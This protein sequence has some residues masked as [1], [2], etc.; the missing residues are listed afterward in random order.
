VIEEIRRSDDSPD[1]LLSRVLFE[2]AYQ[3]HPYRKEVIGTQASVRS[4]TREGLIEFYRSWYVPNNMTFIAVGDFDPAVALEQIKKSFANAKPRAD[5]AHPRAPEPEQTAARAAVVPSQFE[6]SL[7][8]VG[9]KITEFQ[10]PDTPYLDL[11]GMVLGSGDSSRLS[12]EV[13]DRAQLV[14]GIHASSYTPLDPGLFVVDAELDA[15]KIDVTVTAIAEQVRR[16]RDLGP[17]ETE[18]ERA[19]T[20]LLASQVHERETMRGQAQKLG[21]FALLAGG[22][23]AE[24]QYPRRVRRAT[25]R[26]AARREQYL[27]ARARDRGRADREGGERLGDQAQLLGALGAAGS[28]ASLPYNELRDGIRQYTLHNGLRVVV[29]RNA[30]VPLVSLR[31]SFLGGLL[32]ETESTQGITSFV[33]EM[34]SRG[35]MSR[36]SAQLAA[37][38][39]D[40][41]GELSGFSG[42]NSSAYKRSSDESLDTGW[43]SSP[44]CCCAR[45][46]IL[47][48]SKLKIE[49]RAALRCREDSLST[50][51]FELF[52]Q[53]IYPTTRTAS[54]RSAPRSRSRSSIARSQYFTLRAAREQGARV[55]ATSGPHR[56]RD[57]VAPVGLAGHG[58]VAL[59]REPPVARRRRVCSRRRRRRRTVRVLALHLGPRPA[60]A[61]R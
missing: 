36:S 16:I 32:A 61:R 29:K 27:I 12:R 30:N 43:I 1:N 46:S 2:T 11:L 24:A 31:L 22:I 28:A 23:D 6:Q 60:R 45:R 15:D 47:E 54:R 40:I 41:A 51:A 42:R 10:S 48:I 19:R 58:P 26:P 56:R 37:E 49:R 14:H 44:T 17:S 39:E 18:L 34:L 9:W 8:G 53:T 25:G 33:A 20:N 57:R 21:Y 50:K 5:L 3:V 55:W 13:K 7:L 35:T 52:Q 59:P 4:F 38:V